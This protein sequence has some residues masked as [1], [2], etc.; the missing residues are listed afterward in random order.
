MNTKN[1]FG[2]FILGF[3]LLA[4]PIIGEAKPSD[5]N[6]IVAVV[7]NDVIT[8]QEL[9]RRMAM[10]KRQLEGGDISQK[11]NGG[12]RQNVLDGLIDV[13]LQIQMAKKNGIEISDKE[14]NEII[15]NIAKGHNMT[16]DKLKEVLPEQEGMS[17]PEF[18]QQLREQGM[19]TRI[20]QQ[21]FG[22]EITVSAK[23]IDA[24]LHNP[25]KTR[26]VLPQYHVI[27]I[28]LETDEGGSKDQVKVAKN[29]AEK[30]ITKLQGTS[31]VEVVIEESQ[32]N[33]QGTIKSEDLGWRK[34]DEFPELFTKE[35][36]KMKINQ[37]VGP[38]EAPNGLHLLK[39]LAI[40]GGAAATS[41]KLTKDQATEIVFRQ[42]LSEKIGPW[43]KE[44]RESAYIKIIK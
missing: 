23:E 28:L 2:L 4:Q 43:L 32:S 19:I 20:Q 13:L 30:M 10:M 41:A 14:L 27:D 29:V 36:A 38:I 40:S 6:K 26:N 17:F 7:N 35:V 1:I 39:L 24:I 44:L 22:R 21:V 3:L 33:F 5:L 42:K 9:D 15:A 25:P 11:D 34:I 37:I 12:F 31:D 8:Q 18:R 16:I